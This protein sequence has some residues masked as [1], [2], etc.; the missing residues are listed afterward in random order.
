MEALSA[1]EEASQQN[2]N[3]VIDFM[4]QIIVACFLFSLAAVAAAQT[5]ERAGTWE[6][7]FVVIDTGD[8]FLSGQQGTSLDLQSELGWGFWGGY[9]F[10]NHL[11][12]SFDWS[13]V[14]PDYTLTYRRD[15]GGIPGQLE[16]IRHTA[17]IDNLHIKGT[18]NFLEGAFTPFVEAGFGW[19]WADSNV[20][21]GL[22]QT[23]CWW[24]PWWGYVCTSYYDTYDSTNTSY[25]YSAGLRWDISPDFTLRADYGILNVDMSAASG[26]AE[27]EALR[28]A[29]GW[30]F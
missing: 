3:G 14:S 13:H 29:F 10:N 24:D 21:S 16:T 11:G 6:A 4:R 26:S 9:N 2:N 17:D 18:F 30:R 20:A 22:P 8:D 27:F 1:Y 19:T 7:G 23:G 25:T 15:N 12:V 28:I 5:Y